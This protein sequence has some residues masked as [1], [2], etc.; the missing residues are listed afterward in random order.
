VFS[1]AVLIARVADVPKPSSGCVPASGTG[2]DFRPLPPYSGLSGLVRHIGRVRGVVREALTECEAVVVRSP[3]PVASLASRAVIAAGRR[4]G[5]QIVGDPEQV[6]SAGAFR[7]PLR[8]PLR[9]LATAAQKRLSQDASAVLFVTRQVLQRKYP[10]NGLVY[11]ASDVSLD[12]SDFDRQ[13]RNNAG[14]PFTLLTVGSL[15]QP[16]KGTSILLDAAARLLG[17]GADFRLRIIGAGRLRPALQRQS[18]ELGLGPA[19]EFSGQLDRDGVRRALDAADLF[20]L[21]SFTEGLPRALLEAMARGL[22]A[23][24]SDVGGIPELLAREYLVPPGRPQPLAEAIHRLM[25]SE[26]MRTAAAD[27]NRLVARHFHEREQNAIK[28]A[29]LRSVAGAAA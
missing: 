4:Y 3:S 21:P 23:V 26:P 10:T 12:D 19:V 27:R 17:R 28:N 18:D 6:F 13:R 25:T 2:I 22:P 1:G 15:D 8:A 14:Q 16:Y 5:A 24:A 11:S 20:V 9:S 29:F 7:H